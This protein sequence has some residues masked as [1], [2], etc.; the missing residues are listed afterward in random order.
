MWKRNMQ[1]KY[2]AYTIS[3]FNA[4][5]NQI[6]SFGMRKKDYYCHMKFMLLILLSF[7][8]SPDAYASETNYL[9]HMICSL[10]QD[11]GLANCRWVNEAHSNIETRHFASSHVSL[12]GLYA[13][14]SPLSQSMGSIPLNGA[15]PLG[16]PSLSIPSQSF[17]PQIQASFSTSGKFDYT[18]EITSS[19][20]TS[21]EEL[22]KAKETAKQ[23]EAGYIATRRLLGLFLK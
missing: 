21:P 16:A 17:S 9:G 13:N 18:I 23:M 11:G 19:G 4:Q 5:G 15:A 7:I 8:I 20:T 1:N 10:G 3:F 2:I 12:S 6:T 14:A 22:A